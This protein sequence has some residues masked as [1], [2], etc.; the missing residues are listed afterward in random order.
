MLFRFDN[1]ARHVGSREAN[2]WYEWRVFMDEP[3]ETLA[4]VS[5]VEYSLHP[6]FPNP[7]RTSYDAESRFAIESSGWGEFVIPI[8]VVLRDG[9]EHTEYKLDL[10]K[11]WPADQT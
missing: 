4:K 8:M 11:P 9:I 10:S 7:F 1:Y 6:T 5:Y 2:E 3:P